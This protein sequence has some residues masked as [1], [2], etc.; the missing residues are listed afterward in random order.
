MSVCKRVR[1]VLTLLHWVTGSGVHEVADQLERDKR[2]YQNDDK[3]D[4]GAV[5]KTAAALGLETIQ[6]PVGGE[7]KSYPHECEI[8]DFHDVCTP[9]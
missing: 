8:N 3:K 7:V 9:C 2:Q 1:E 6:N 4:D 5:F